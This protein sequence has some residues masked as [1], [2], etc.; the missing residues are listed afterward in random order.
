MTLEIYLS[1]PW[2]RLDCEIFM[3][4]VSCGDL[5]RALRDTCVDGVVAIM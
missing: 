3:V 2:E 4:S 1:L 5:A